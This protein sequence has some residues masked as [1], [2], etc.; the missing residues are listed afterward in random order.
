M[1]LGAFSSVALPLLLC[2]CV[3]GRGP[4]KPVAYRLEVGDGGEAMLD[5]PGGVRANV[6]GP[7]VVESLAAEAFE[8]PTDETPTGVVTSQ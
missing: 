2:G 1:R 7:V 4:D 8:A 3:L 5:L 6:R